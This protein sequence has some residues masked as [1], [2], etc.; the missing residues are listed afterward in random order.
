M[1]ASVY[2]EACDIMALPLSLYVQVFP[3]CPEIT[4][5]M[6]F[7]ACIFKTF[8]VHPSSFSHPTPTPR[9]C[10]VA[11]THSTYD[12]MINIMWYHYVV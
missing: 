11:S 1:D 10:S 5:M 7:S 6:D 4:A 12:L 3:F 9:R 8:W 2:T